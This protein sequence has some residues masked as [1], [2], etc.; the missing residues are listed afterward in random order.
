MA[1]PSP[2]VFGLELWF[3]GTILRHQAAA[4]ADSFPQDLSLVQLLAQR[5][6]LLPLAG[7]DGSG[8]TF[9][10]ESDD[11]V[12]ADA[13]ALADDG[14]AATHAPSDT[15]VIAPDPSVHSA[16]P[17]WFQPRGNSGCMYTH[18][19]RHYAGNNNSLQTQTTR[20][21]SSRRPTHLR[22]RFGKLMSSV[23]SPPRATHS[24]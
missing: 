5:L 8:C 15:W 24:P 16:F 22:L 17:T 13:E 9:R 4:V 7:P 14:V 6:Q 10:Q 2:L 19:A 18:L 20:T 1:I 21:K 12:D 23:C 11:E 3:Y